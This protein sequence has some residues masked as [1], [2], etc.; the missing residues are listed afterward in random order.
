MD[1]SQTDELEIINGVTFVCRILLVGLVLALSVVWARLFNHGGAAEIADSNINVP[2]NYAWILFVILTFAHRIYSKHLI[3]N[4]LTFWE[5]NPDASKGRRVFEQIRTHPNM[6]VFGLIPRVEKK[7]SMGRTNY[8]MD[9]SDPSTAFSHF[10]LIAFLVSMLPW[11]ITTGGDLKWAT[12]WALWLPIIA[13]L[14]IAWMNWSYAGAWII[15]LSQLTLE[16]DEAEYL[17]S[18]QKPKHPEDQEDT[19]GKYQPDATTSPES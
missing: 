5:S 3:S 19:T 10:A 1:L 11:Y 12:G 16:K 17:I 13:A 8:L 15:A 6:F 4:V 2:A 7:R 18:L 14:I 9:W